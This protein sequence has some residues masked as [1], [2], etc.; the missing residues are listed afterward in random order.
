MLKSRPEVISPDTLIV[1]EEF[2]DWEDSRRRIDLLG[3][4]KTANL[5]VI[6][7]KR[8]ED[9][10][11]MELQAVRYA[12]MVSALTFD[13]LVEH[14]EQFLK[15]NDDERDARDRLLDFLNWDDSDDQT[16]GQ[17]T[18]IVLASAEFSKELTT[19]ILWLNEQGLDI[20]CVRLRPYDNCGQ[21]LLDVQTIIPIPEAE[22]YQIRIRE[23][24]Q[25][26]RAARESNRDYSKFD[27]TIGDEQYPKKN[28]RKMI[29]LIVSAVLDNGGS[30]QR[31]LETVPA[32]K[33]RVF[34]G[35]L[36]AEQIREQLD[37]EDS[38]GSVHRSQRYFCDDGQP[39]QI[40]GK[41]YILSNQ[42]GRNA[43]V[44]ARNIAG[45]FPEL[46]IKIEKTNTI[47][48]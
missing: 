5:V 28:K 48:E 34:D 31:V 32:K 10:G 3:I 21:V 29:F 25:R 46:K 24:R 36:D 44:I 18:Q 9:G 27:V 19:S 37:E 2:A 30:L 20:R 12:A 35:A 39:F 1:A 26:E 45:L 22:E 8:T 15:K 42:W 47:A 17:N 40:E 16:F 11:H 13:M 6:E 43:P 14:Y 23:K 41:T 4:D 33:I 38:G 7:L